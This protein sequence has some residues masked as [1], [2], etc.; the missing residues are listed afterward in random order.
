VHRRLISWWPVPQLDANPVLW[1]EWHRTRPSRIAR[2]VMTL[3][4]TIVA[5]ALVVNVRDALKHGVTSF[6]LAGTNYLG[7][8]FGLLMVSATAPTVFTEE[9]ARGSLDVLLATPLSTASIVLGKWWSVFRRWLPLMLLPLFCGVFTALALPDGPPS[10]YVLLGA[11]RTQFDRIAAA[12]RVCVAVLPVGFALAHAAATT[13]MGVALGAWLRH[14]GRAIAASVT[15]FVAACIGWIV[16]IELLRSPWFGRFAS[17][18]FLTRSETR[19][20]L[21]ESLCCL[22]PLGSQVEPFDTVSFYYRQDSPHWLVWSAHW[23]DL[24]LVAALGAA[25]LGL[26]L[27]TFNR[28][29]GRMPEGAAHSTRRVHKKPD[30]D[31]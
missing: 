26:T 25:L 6:G 31:S 22:S 3:Y 10:H 30:F 2:L 24:G 1:R 15:V 23:V 13:S 8:T 12:D 28:C 9:R 19:R 7:V 21:T 29:M 20:R 5:V 4:L 18:Q 11:V 16:A 17:V 14:T 27:A